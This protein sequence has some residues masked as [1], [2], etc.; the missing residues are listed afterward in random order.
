MLKTNSSKPR[1]RLRPGPSAI[2][3]GRTTSTIMSSDEEGGRERPEIL[4]GTRTVVSQQSSG[5][6]RLR[7]GQRALSPI[8]ASQYQTLHAS[9]KEK[10]VGGE[11]EE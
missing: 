11:E 10:E 6:S 2:G 4:P 5:K 8:E 3:A 7:I 9:T 1:R